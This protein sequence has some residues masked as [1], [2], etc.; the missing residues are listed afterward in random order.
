MDENLQFMGR[1]SLLER[2][3]PLVGNTDLDS[4]CEVILDLL[5]SAAAA[6]SG[7]LWVQH[8][9]AGPLVRQSSRSESREQESRLSLPARLAPHRAL[10]CVLPPSIRRRFD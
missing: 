8:E 6:E 9:P 10:G 4:A 3:L 2:A 7:V 5:C 1:L